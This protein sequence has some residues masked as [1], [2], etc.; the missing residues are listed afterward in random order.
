MTP[1]VSDAKRATLSLN[2]SSKIDCR[3]DVFAPI[4]GG[5]KLRRCRRKILGSKDDGG[6]VDEWSPLVVVPFVKAGWG[7]ILVMTRLY[8]VSSTLSVDLRA[9]LCLFRKFKA[10]VKGFRR[11]SWMQMF[12]LNAV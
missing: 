12:K 10:I 8:A 6:S 7:S 11:G 4:T 2:S 3:S 5:N 1:P 9:N